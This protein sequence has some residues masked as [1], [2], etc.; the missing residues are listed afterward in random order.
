MFVSRTMRHLALLGVLLFAGALSAQEKIEADVHSFATPQHVR[1]KHV[2]LDLNVDFERQRIEGQVVLTIERT[3]KDASQPL[4]LDSRKLHLRKVETSTD[5][6]AYAPAKYEV[7]KEDAIL[8]SPIAVTLAEGVK[9]VRIDYATDARA[10][11][12]QW[13][14]R[15]MTAGKKH[16]FLFTQSQAI[17]ARSWIPLQDSP[18]IRIT[19]DARIRTPKGLLA[20]MSAENDP[21]NPRSG[22]HRFRMT[23]PIPPYL[24]ALAVG[25]LQFE[26]L[27]ERTGVY[28]EPGIVEKAAK[29]FSDLEAMVK[30]VEGLYGPY[31]WDRYDVLVLPPSF[32]F[33]GMENPRLTFVSPTVLAGDKSLVSLLAH[34]LAHSWSGNLVS[35]ATWSDFWLNEG[36]TV[37]LERRI[38]EKVY[39]KQRAVTEAVLGR[40]SLEREMADLKLSDQI[41]HI[42]LKGRDPDDGLT[43]IAYEKG[44][45]FLTHL[46][47][48]FG[49]EKFDAFLKS[50]FDRFAFRSITTAQFAAYLHEHLLKANPQLAAKVPVKEWLYKPGLPGSAPSFRAMTLEAVEKQAKAWGDGKIAANELKTADWSTQEWLHFLTVLPEKLSPD[51]MKELDAALKLTPR[52]NA[53][54]AFQWLLLSIRH[55]YEP[56]YPRLEDFLTVQGRRKFLRPLYEELVKTPEGRERAARIYARAR[57]TYHPISAASIDAILNKR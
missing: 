42:D 1:V 34:E 37:Y 15:E 55:G 24:L 10:S 56:A 51:R 3:S 35:N 38:T 46:E 19:Y 47:T 39:G 40:R 2:V 13:L 49:R 18:G 14:T 36:F 6:D 43:D 57:A 8:G 21:N 25:D 52:T 54:I 45:L 48:T 9:F 5:G 7:G 22:E 32:P 27:G 23:Q 41:L 30:A 29:E 4:T 50:Y 44:A 17:H 20:L 12:L 53:E 11:A 33:G 28:G 31:R 16:P 26:K